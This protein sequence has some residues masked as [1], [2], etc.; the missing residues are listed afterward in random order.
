MSERDHETEAE[1]ADP[2]SPEPAADEPPEQ[3]KVR[4]VRRRRPGL[5]IGLALLV[6]AAAFAGGLAA[7]PV[8]AP[9]L[10][11]SIVRTLLGDA[12]FTRLDAIEARLTTVEAAVEKPDPAIAG[13]RAAAERSS[14]ALA[15][16]DERVARLEGAEP[17]A[18]LEAI[19]ARLAALEGM[20]GSASP[21]GEAASEALATRLEAVE[22]R[23]AAL[24]AGPAAAGEDATNTALAARLAAI[25]RAL[26]EARDAARA[27]RAGLEALRRETARLGGDVAAQGKRLAAAERRGAEPPGAAVPPTAPFVLAVGQLRAALRTAAPFERELAALVALL[28]EDGDGDPDLVAAVEALR[29]IA[30]GGAPTLADL[31]ARFGATANRVA[32]AAIE[33]AGDWLGRTLSRLAALVTVRRTGEVEGS[34]PD[35]I[36]ARAERRLADG[37]LAA[38]VAEVEALEGAAAD[39]AA[40]WL[41][42]ARKRLAAE[43]A[44]AALHRLALARLGPDD[45]TIR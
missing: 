41:A 15:A 31:R 44:V 34:A 38:A 33:P 22:E 26:E 29:P 18:R 23:L 1:A 20:A 17:T 8:L 16:L 14:K 39:A 24:E 19:E 9:K 27:N 40:E 25:E 45:R 42:A 5:R 4:V 12:L 2:P 36:M 21:P 28:P 7:W 13:L 11:V 3:A 35:A 6:L 37:D 43:R 30:A 10:G 32:R